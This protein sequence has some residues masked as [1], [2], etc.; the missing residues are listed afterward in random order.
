VCS[1]VTGSDTWLACELCEG[2]FHS[3]CVNVKDDAYKIL[4]ELE[5]CHWYCSQ[6]N[7]KLG[8]IIPTMVKLHDRIQDVDNRVAKMENDMKVHIGNVI[9][10]K[11][12]ITEK[13]TEA[14][15]SMIKNLKDIKIDWHG[16]LTQLDLSLVEYD[17]KMDDM[18]HEI[19][20]EIASSI[21]GVKREMQNV[22]DDNTSVKR[23]ASEDP[24]FAEVVAKEVDAK[25]GLVSNEMRTMQKTL[26]ETRAAVTEEQD[27]ENRR[28]NVIL[29]RVPESTAGTVVE[30]SADDK[31]FCDQFVVAL[32]TG[33]VGEDLK[34]I[35]RLGKRS[36][37]LTEP[38]PLLIQLSSRWAKNALMENLGKLRSLEA[39][40]K[41]VIVAHDMTVNERNV[42]KGLVRQAKEKTEQ[43][44]GDFVYRVRGPPGHMIIQRFR[45]RN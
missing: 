19:R 11:Q 42:C 5:T 14:E 40:F 3:K 36:E 28:N 20:Q 35:F 45:I 16:K 17:K 29:Y 24:S 10:I 34:K 22:L 27:K 41:N 32:Q 30:R 13:M 33:V 15:N 26:T 38:R 12:D 21:D 39:K 44:S 9:K 43:D 2:W 8:K 1:K 31:C 25:L 6:C 18:R 7:V 4:Q 23:V 37:D